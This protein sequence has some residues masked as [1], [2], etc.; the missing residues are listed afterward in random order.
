MLDYLRKPKGRLITLDRPDQ[1]FLFE[2]IDEEL[3]TCRLQ[4]TDWVIQHVEVPETVFDGTSEYTVTDIAR[5]A[6]KDSVVTSIS[7][8]K[9]IKHI[10][11][12][13]F[14][15]CRNLKSID[16]PDGLESI[17]DSAFASSGLTEV[18]I[19]DTVTE[20]GILAFEDC[21]NLKSAMLSQSLTSVSPL[22]FNLCTQLKE[23]ILPNEL[24]LIKERAF[25]FCRAL[26]A[27]NFGGKLKGIGFRAFEGCTQLTTID[28]PKSVERIE[29]GAFMSCKKLWYAHIE[30]PNIEM[31]G[32]VF[33][34]SGLTTVVCENKS[35]ANYAFYEN[36]KLSS[37]YFSN[38]VERIGGYVFKG[39]ERLVSIYFPASVKII[40]KNAFEGCRCLNVVSIRGDISEFN[41]DAFANCEAITD[42]YCFASK[43][44]K[45]ISRHAAYSGKIHREEI[46]LHVRPSSV[47]A[48]KAHS[49]WN[50]FKIIEGDL[51]CD[52]IDDIT[53]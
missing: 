26:I 45:W 49:E 30:S 47:E 35:V 25:Q 20:I 4:K 12:S 41:E 18:K 33:R 51:D 40:E 22:L 53:E 29:N 39:C 50:R 38:T 21:S 3:K 37:V 44:P 36:T 2:V 46:T 31:E 9:T 27:I 1:Q 16:L 48:Y 5:G 8:P 15:S 23:V 43:P 52:V 7:L 32:E 6:I 24:I 34:E 10:E 13:C 14:K 19:P 42:I 11:S 28:I 17:G